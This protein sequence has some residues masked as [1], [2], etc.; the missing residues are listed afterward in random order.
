MQH[1]LEWLERWSWR[2]WFRCD[3]LQEQVDELRRAS[4]ASLLCFYFPCKNFA[5]AVEIFFATI[6]YYYYEYFYD[7]YYDYY[8]DYYYDYYYDYSYDYY[9]HDYYYDYYYAYYFSM[10]IIIITT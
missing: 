10:I 9:Y 5:F 1:T 4:R 6:L 3:N 8:N 2:T 7:Y